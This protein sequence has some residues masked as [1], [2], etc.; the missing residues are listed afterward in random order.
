MTP[1]SESC[2]YLLL[3]LFSSGAVRKVVLKWKRRLYSATESLPVAN[4]MNNQTI[5]KQ[6]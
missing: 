6:A 3:L 4:V 5:Y 1:V 2:K